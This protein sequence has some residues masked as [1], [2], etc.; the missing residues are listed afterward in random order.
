[1]LRPAFLTLAAA[2]LLQGCCCCCGGGSSSSSSS[3]SGD[4]LFSGLSEG[5]ERRAT[6]F[7][8]ERVTGA[9]RI[10][11]D[12]ESGRLEIV[13]PDGTLVFEEDG[14]E[15]R[16][17]FSGT[18]GDLEFSSGGGEV[19]PDFPLP[20]YPGAEVMGSSRGATAEGSGWLLALRTDDAPE[21]AVTYYEGE[22]ASH[23]EMTRQ[24]MAIGGEGA[25]QILVEGPDR[26][27]MVMITPQDGATAIVLTTGT[28]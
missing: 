1:M 18:E 21:Q 10:R 4:G 2:T 12:E 20:V 11:I 14:E 16:L 17:T 13:G 28:N 5:V 15:G 22:L 27:A 7:V 3:S 25:T 24:E 8:A 6:E 19:P 9:D 23:G 26:T